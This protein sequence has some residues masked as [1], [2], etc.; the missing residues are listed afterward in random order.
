MK[1][2]LATALAA[3]TVF[4]VAAA[5]TTDYEGVDPSGQQITYW[6][7]FSDQREETLNQ[8]VQAFNTSN[9]YGVT[10]TAAG[11]G[12]YGDLFQK[13]LPLL[14]TDAAPDLVVAYQNQAATYQLANAL[15]DM[16]PLVESSTWGL[17]QADLSDFYPN[18]LE[19]GRFPHL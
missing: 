5:Q 7:P 13:M 10:V 3:T 16:T 9:E 18:F 17:S 11:Q 8:I 14:N 15:V 6:H 19:Q 4:G 12:D 1:V 2:L